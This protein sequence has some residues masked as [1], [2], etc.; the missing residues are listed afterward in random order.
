MLATAALA[1]SLVVRVYD[2]TGLPPGERTAALSVARAILGEAGI[3]VTWRDGSECGDVT[4]RRER[5]R[6]EPAFPPEVII[7]IVTAPPGAPLDS[8]GF[9]LVDVVERAGTLATVYADRVTDLARLGDIEMGRLLGWAMAHEVGHLLLGTTRHANRG[10]MRGTW[11]TDELRLDR[12]W[13]WML[14]REDIV[15]MRGGLTARARRLEQ[16][17]TVLA[18]QGHGT[19]NLEP[20]NL[21]PLNLEPLNP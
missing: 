4:E 10:L 11:T 7:R 19:S 15:R 12:P 9:S 3:A 21:E 5:S 8:L 17:D 2:G 20:L 16:P 13:D 18:Q 6:N 1:L 14:L